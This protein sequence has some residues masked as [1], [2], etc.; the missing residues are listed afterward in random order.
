M[1]ADLDLSARPGRRLADPRPRRH[2]VGER[3]RAGPRRRGR[4]G[5][6][7]VRSPAGDRGSA[8]PWWPAPT[9]GRAERVVVA[10]HL[11]TVP[12]NDN[13]PARLDDD[14]LH[15]L[16]QLR[17]EGR[18]RRRPAARRRGRRAGPRR[19][20]P[21]LRLRG[22]RGGAQR[23]RTGWP[24]RIPDLLRGRLRDPDGAVERRASRPAARAPCGSRSRPAARAPTRPGRGWATTPSTPPPR[25]WRGC[26]RTSRGTPGH[27]RAGVPR[28][29]Q[30]RAA[31]VVAWPATSSPTSAW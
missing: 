10:G 24:P 21:L 28:G 17:H 25:C 31:S 22:G 27:R 7:P 14:F 18:G 1:T 5:A 16:R 11:D 9:L 30:R 4:G 29:A 26:R 13:L 20:L 3:R 19:H 8:T 6:R 23:A 2:P 12:V 15:G